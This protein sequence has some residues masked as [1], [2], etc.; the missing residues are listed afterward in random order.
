MA[1]EPHANLWWLP[2]G[3]GG[4]FVV[5]TSRWWEALS[6]RRQGRDAQPLCH[7]ALEVFT[8]SSRVVVEMA[9]AWGS[10]AGTQ[11]VRATGPVGLHFLGRSRLFRYEVRSWV[12]G[13]IPDRAAA[14]TDPLRIPLGA[15]QAEELVARVSEAPLWTW[16]RD[17]LGIGDMWNSNS[18]V[19]WLLE[20]SGVDTASIGAPPPYRSPGWLC[21]RA[22]A[23]RG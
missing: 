15:C 17:V 7:A 18:L 1:D 16:G 19:A 13:E 20:T 9:P 22:A 23:G 2:V 8:V 3:A 21:G 10:G 4:H 14:V 6:A 5:H 12:G 11:A